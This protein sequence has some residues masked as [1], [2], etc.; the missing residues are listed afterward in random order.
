VEKNNRNTE[1]N[2]IKY[3]LQHQYEINESLKQ[4]LNKV[5]QQAEVALK[6]ITKD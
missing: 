1:K 2:T 4:K 6:K 5:T 3:I